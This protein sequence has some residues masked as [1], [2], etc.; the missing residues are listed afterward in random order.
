LGRK[1]ASSV[2]R[3]R[4]GSKKASGLDA[5]GIGKKAFLYRVCGYYVVEENQVMG[6]TRKKESK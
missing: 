2:D 4:L 5:G 3:Q 1:L 6:D